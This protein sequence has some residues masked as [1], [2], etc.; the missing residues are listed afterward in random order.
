MKIESDGE[1]VLEVCPS[2]E[3]LR[4]LAVTPDGAGLADVA[5]HVFVCD[6][7]RNIFE[8]CLYPQEESAITV[9]DRRIIDDF[10]QSRCR[11]YSPLRQLQTWVLKHPPVPCPVV[12]SAGGES[13]FR[14]AAA[15]DSRRAKTADSETVIITYASCCGRDSAASWRAELTLPSA[16]T[17]KTRMSLLVKEGNGCLSEGVFVVAGVRTLLHHGRGD[18]AYSSFVEGIRDSKVSL[19]RLDGTE[20]PGILVLF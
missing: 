18:I 17:D 20:T 16:P 6:K 3:Q 5:A 1:I 8:E 7:C 12:V 2:R 14:K 13:Y 19:E 4:Q 11:E 15:K 9:G 10:V